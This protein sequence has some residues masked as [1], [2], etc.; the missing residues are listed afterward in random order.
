MVNCTWNYQNVKLQITSLHYYKFYM[1]L[2]FR[3]LRCWSD[4]IFCD[5]HS[6]SADHCL[7]IGKKVV[8][9]SFWF[10]ASHIWESCSCTRLKS[11]N[12]RCENVIQNDCWGLFLM[13][14]IDLFINI[15]LLNIRPKSEEWVFNRISLLEKKKSRWYRWYILWWY[16]TQEI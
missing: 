14:L 11:S 8:T 12:L 9:L 2:Y 1:S 4:N 15:Y 5:L 6:S 3:Y 16:F 10:I 13:R 7:H